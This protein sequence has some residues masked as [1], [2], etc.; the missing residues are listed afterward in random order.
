MSAVIVT[1]PH[2][3]VV[4]TIRSLSTSQLGPRR[5]NKIQCHLCSVTIHPRP[6][7]F[8]WAASLSKTFTR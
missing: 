4:V 6:K 1:F 7:P 3:S 2:L 5:P 8:W